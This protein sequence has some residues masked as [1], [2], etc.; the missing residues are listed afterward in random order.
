MGVMKTKC[1]TAMKGT[2]NHA[3]TSFSTEVCAGAIV[4]VVQYLAL[5]RDIKCAFSACM[6]DSSENCF[7]FVG[8]LKRKKAYGTGR[9]SWRVAK[10]C[11]L[12]L[13]HLAIG[14]L[15]CQ[16]ICSQQ[17]KTLPFDKTVFRLV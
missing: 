6:H 2:E 5:L 7:F 17:F 10:T 3:K 8:C 4:C 9:C 15:S 13:L 12:R 1:P 11:G 16:R 14:K